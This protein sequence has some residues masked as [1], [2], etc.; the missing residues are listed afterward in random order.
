MH[1]HYSVPVPKAPRATNPDGLSFPLTRR[2]APM[3][4]ILR[5]ILSGLAI[6]VALGAPV[7]GLLA[8]ALRQPLDRRGYVRRDL[9]SSA[10]RL[11]IIAAALTA[12]ALGALLDWELSALHAAP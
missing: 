9:D 4:P 12:A 7:V 1:L 11:L 3:P 6:A 5:T 8:W 2:A 10:I